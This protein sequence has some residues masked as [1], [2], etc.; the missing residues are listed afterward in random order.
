MLSSCQI[1]NVHENYYHHHHHHRDRLCVLCTSIYRITQYF[2]KTTST[3]HAHT[4]THT[5]SHRHP[6]THSIPPLTPNA[7]QG[8]AQRVL[9]FLYEDIDACLHT[10]VVAFLYSS[11]HKKEKAA[12]EMNMQRSFHAMALGDIMDLAD[13]P[14]SQLYGLVTPDLAANCLIRSCELLSDI[15][16]THYLI[17]QWHLSP[18]DQRNLDPGFLHR[19]PVDLFEAEDS[20][21]TI[22]LNSPDTIKEKEKGKEKEKKGGKDKVCMYVL[23]LS[24]VKIAFFSVLRTELLESLKRAFIL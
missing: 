24:A 5:H 1:S 20:S 23:T 9:R 10:S 22:L 4:H 11:Q 8:L 12:K 6:L 2:L 17:A 3:P 18:F 16:H 7:P 19:C 14:L 21:E 15:V 13:A